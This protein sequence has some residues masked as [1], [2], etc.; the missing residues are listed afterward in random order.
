MDEERETERYILVYA[1]NGY[2]W[3]PEEKVAYQ[4]E[5]C[6]EICSEI[7]LIDQ[8]D[9]KIMLEY[10]TYVT[11]ALMT[12]ENFGILRKKLRTLVSRFELLYKGQLLDFIGAIDEFERTQTL[13]QEVFS[14]KDIFES[15]I[16]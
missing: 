2:E 16:G 6:S 5:D 3:L 13:V 15:Q 12:E 10:G 4:I 11:G 9:L 14:P 8:E 7:K 1:I